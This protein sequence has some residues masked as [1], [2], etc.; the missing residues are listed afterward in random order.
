MVSRRDEYGITA[1]EGEVLEILATT[2][3]TNLQIAKRTNMAEKTVKAH[4]YQLCQ[5]LGQQNRV[6]LVIWAWGSGWLH[7]RQ[8]F[9]QGR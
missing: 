6:Q 9:W 3:E 8:A 2:G 4:M 1:R 7:Q 5:K